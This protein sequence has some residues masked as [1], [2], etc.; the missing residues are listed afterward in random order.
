[1]SNNRGQEVLVMEDIYKDITSENTIKA[2]KRA[3]GKLDA[4]S[5]N[6]KTLDR[7]TLS[8]LIISSNNGISYKKQ[9]MA[10]RRRLYL[11]NDKEAK[12]W[13]EQMDKLE[14]ID[15]QERPMKT[16]DELQKVGLE[17]KKLAPKI[18]KRSKSTTLSREKRKELDNWKKSSKKLEEELKKK[19]KNLEKLKR[20]KDW[21]E[22]EKRRGK[23]EN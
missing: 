23:E 20:K 10:V 9:M 4:L 5:S 21:N 14:N 1:M 19:K 22:N 8:P 3:E 12:Y 6:W 18:R 17:K 13:N 2:Y 7:T 15:I 16:A 11:S